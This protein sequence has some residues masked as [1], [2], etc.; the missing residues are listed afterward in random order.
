MAAETE[1]DV[2]AV[3]QEQHEQ[4]GRLFSQVQGLTGKDAL[5]P[6]Q[7]LTCLLAVH[8]TAEEMVV[9]PAL[10]TVPGGEA[11]AERRKDEESRAEQALSDV[12]SLGPDSTAFAGRRASFKT[13]VEEHAQPRKTR[14]CRSCGPSAAP[15]SWGRC[16]RCSRRPS[17]PRRP[18]LIP[19]ARTGRSAT[20]WW[21]RL[22]PSWT[23][24]GTRCA[25]RG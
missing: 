15:R 12:E 20:W 14:C 5:G 22:S 18:T 25:R 4:V 2:V 7:E 23:R 19:T 3:I 6:F 17:G 21:V 24:S 16:V 10:R 8:G 1:Q 9:Y 13:M 11:V